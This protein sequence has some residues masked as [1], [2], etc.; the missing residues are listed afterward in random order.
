MGIKPANQYADVASARRGS[1]GE[2][3]CAPNVHIPKLGV[4]LPLVEWFWRELKEGG[5]LQKY[6]ARERSAE[7]TR[8][9][10]RAVARRQHGIQHNYKSELK[11]VADIP[12]RDYMRWNEDDK[13]FWDDDK[14]LRKLKNDNPDHHMTIYV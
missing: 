5:M 4:D 2:S 6:M 10:W 3:P 11:R 13:H 9:R 1:A 7:A 8:N 12:L 14:N